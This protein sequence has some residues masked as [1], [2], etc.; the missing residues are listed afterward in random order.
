VNVRRVDDKGREERTVVVDEERAPLVKLAFEEY[1][2]G[3]WTVL[4]LAEHLAS[5]G[6]TTRATP[7]IPSAPIN[8]SALNKI[9]VNPFY[10]GTTKYKGV[11]YTGNHTPLVDAETWQK[12]QDVLY[13][14]LNGE[15]NRE[16]P[17]YLKGS[18]FCKNCGSRMIITYAK[19]RSGVRY[20]YFVCAG[21]HNKRTDCDCRAILIEEVAESVEH[22][23]ERR[24]LP[25]EMRVLLEDVVSAEVKKWQKQFETEH[26]GLRRE[27]EKLERK[28]KKLLEAHYNDAIPLDL[29]KS[30]QSEVNKALAEIEHRIKAHDIH[31]DLLIANLGKALD[32]I[33]NCGR[34]YR[35]AEDH[36]KKIL[37]Q[38]L[39]VNIWIGS[40]GKIT[41]ELSE[42]FKS[43]LQP[44]ESDIVQYNRAKAKGIPNLTDYL[45]KASNHIQKFFGCG[46]KLL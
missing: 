14:H 46:L 24:S 25:P 13:S 17:H 3:K 8:R 30:E 45:I 35:L 36:I 32:M 19:S 10:R 23:Y 40:E 27:K 12:V 4:D 33:E 43:M 44:I 31:C 42:P 26:A 5:L 20:P 21:R 16:H 37:N 1:A 34:T 18:V 28:R 39:G 41:T 9:L 6:L 11:E 38:A 15:R 7:K 22:D 29:L 2:T